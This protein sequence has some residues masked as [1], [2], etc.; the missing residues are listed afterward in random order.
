MRLNEA[1]RSLGETPYWVFVSFLYAFIAADIAQRFS[2]LSSHWSE[3]EEKSEYAWGGLHFWYV[4]VYSHLILLSFVVGTSWLGWSQFVLDH[5]EM[6]ELR[7]GVLTSSSLLLIVDFAIL[8]LY[9]SFASVLNDAR[10]SGKYT[11]L[12]SEYSGHAGYWVCV[13]L[14]TYAI[15][16]FF[17]FFLIP[18]LRSPAPLAV[19]R[20]IVWAVLAVALGRLFLF[21]LRSKPCEWKFVAALITTVVLL[22]LVYFWIPWC[23]DPKVAKN[24]WLKSWMSLVCTALAGLAFFAF[25]RI[26]ESRAVGISLADSSLIALILFY[27]GLRQPP[28]SDS[29]TTQSVAM[30]AHIPVA[31]HTVFTCGCFVV[32]LALGLSAC[33]FGRFGPKIS[34]WLESHNWRRL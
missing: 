5:L 13:I 15:W 24:L 22:G 7:L 4:P 20:W 11:G 29:A 31:W 21:C 23:I 3:L 8:T 32:F 19:G 14:G 1:T 25:A 6:F 34:A 18:R 12:W 9:S 2:K 27:R 26:P 17:V 10:L 33:V 28:S 16:D 30:V